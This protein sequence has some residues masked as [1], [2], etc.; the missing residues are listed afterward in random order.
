MNEGTHKKPQRSIWGDVTAWLL[1]LVLALI[2]PFAL[3]FAVILMGFKKI[4]GI[5]AHASK[6]E[7]RG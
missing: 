2:V 7:Q 4:S 6:R 3:F 1:V 5:P